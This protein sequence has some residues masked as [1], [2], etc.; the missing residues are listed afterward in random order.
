[1]VLVLQGSS[2]VVVGVDCEVVLYG[3]RRGNNA[4]ARRVRECFSPDG[5]IRLVSFRVGVKL[6]AEI[7]VQGCEAT[8]AVCFV[9][10]CLSL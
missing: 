8:A 3:A 9:S 1:M 7:R 4:S 2:K 6:R 5:K 10:D